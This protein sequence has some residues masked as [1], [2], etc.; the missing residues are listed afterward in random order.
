M[1]TSMIDRERHRLI[2]LAYQKRDDALADEI[3][4]IDEK[5]FSLRPTTVSSVLL[6]ERLDQLLQIA[7]IRWSCDFSIP[8]HSERKIDR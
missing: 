2:D 5:L 3:V 8:N 1:K 7:F 4:A 6:T